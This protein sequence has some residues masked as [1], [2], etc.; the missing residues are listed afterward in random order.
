MNP[1]FTS[2]AIR[3]DVYV[4][5]VISKR[6]KCR[7]GEGGGMLEVAADA[8]AE[9]RIGK[10][11]GNKRKMRHTKARSKQRRKEKLREKQNRT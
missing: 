1:A 2:R 4:T 3:L 8:N 11:E 9:R 10:K 6:I 7:V 5:G